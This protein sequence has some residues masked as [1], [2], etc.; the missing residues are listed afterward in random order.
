MGS[1]N[2]YSKPLI[3]NVGTEEGYNENDSDSET[4]WLFGIQEFLVNCIQ[5][6]FFLFKKLDSHCY[7]L[8]YYYWPKLSQL[9]CERISKVDN[10]LAFNKKF[11][12]FVGMHSH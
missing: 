4:F 8:K 7:I 6:F 11:G 5:V 1:I 10:N 12:G 9:G 2:S 3:N